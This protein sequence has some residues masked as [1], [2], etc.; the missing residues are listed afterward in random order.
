MSQ[1]QAIR[2]KKRV[3]TRSEV[4]RNLPVAR[5]MVKYPADYEDA[6]FFNW[7]WILASYAG[8]KAT[9]VYS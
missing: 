6:S 3:P 2:Y 5:I 8:H 7:A 1:Q 4:E 9:G